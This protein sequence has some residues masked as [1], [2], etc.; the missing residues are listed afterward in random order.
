MAITPA[1][2]VRV[3]ARLRPPLP[4]EV[5]DDGVRVVSHV[6]RGG[7]KEKENV[8][9]TQ[10]SDL[11]PGILILKDP[12]SSSLT[13]QTQHYPFH[14]AYT[15]HSTSAAL[16][17]RDVL[18]LLNNVLGGSTVTIFAYGVTSSG[19]THTMQGEEG[20]IGMVV[21]E[22]FKGE[23]ELDISMS[24]LEL[25]LDAPYDLL[26]PPTQR[27]KLQILSTVSRGTNPNPKNTTFGHTIHLPHLS[28]HPISSVAEFHTLYQRGVRHRSTG[29][30][31]LNSGSSRSH[32]VLTFYIG[33]RGKLHLLDLAGSENNNLTGNDPQRMRESAA[34]NTS[35]SA[36]GQVVGALNEKSGGSGA[37]IPYRSSNL[38]RLLSDALGGTSLALLI[39]CLAPGVKFRG[40]LVRSV[41]FASKAQRIQ[42]KLPPPPPPPAHPAATTPLSSISKK[43][44]VPSSKTFNFAVPFRS[45][46][47]ALPS[48]SS[49]STLRTTSTSTSTSAVSRPP[50][51]LRPSRPSR[52]RLSVHTHSRTR[53]GSGSN[54]NSNSNPSYLS[55]HRSSLP[56]SSI[57]S[58]RSSRSSLPRLSSRPLRSSLNSCSSRR[59]STALSSVPLPIPRKSFI[60]LPLPL[61]QPRLGVLVPRSSFAPPVPPLAP[62]WQFS[63][64]THPPGGSVSTDT[65]PSTS[66][67][68]ASTSTTPAPAENHTTNLSPVPERVEAL[69]LPRSRIGRYSGGGGGGGGGRGIRRSSIPSFLREARSD[70]DARDEQQIRADK[71]HQDSGEDT[72]SSGDV[73]VDVMDVMM[74]DGVMDDEEGRE[75]VGFCEEKEE[76][77][78][79]GVMV[80]V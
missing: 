46:N 35:L 36:L 71:K 59:L 52:T 2:R 48:S 70:V 25:Y 1:A 22:L 15:P 24:Y 37:R 56:C 8:N 20:I 5:C 57:S 55:L 44:T 23:G 50:R 30:T 42:N 28:T 79:G 3:I 74:M 6:H 19:K 67:T 7:E 32:A 47:T 16:F 76:P 14:S 29:A 53:S 69:Y 39:V 41:N 78:V 77:K 9:D 10:P 64:G 72:I 26:V 61:A 40:D 33:A 21:D 34:I 75:L 4:G 27:R 12:S 58:S 80:V 18:P 73:D 43:P 54:H 11:A 63:R 51:L 68:T 49:T 62:V 38:T 13:Q 66:A 60:P 17:T 45:S 65:T 31:L